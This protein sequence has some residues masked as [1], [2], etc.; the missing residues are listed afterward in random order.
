MLMRRNNWLINAIGSELVR[1]G[2]AIEFDPDP[3]LN[4]LYLSIKFKGLF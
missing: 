2:I 4:K 3:D 1:V